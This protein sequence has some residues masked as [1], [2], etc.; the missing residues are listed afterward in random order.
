M[1]DQHSHTD[2]ADRWLIYF[3]DVHVRAITQCRPNAARPIM[4]PDATSRD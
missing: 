1:F 4:M 3:G 2:R